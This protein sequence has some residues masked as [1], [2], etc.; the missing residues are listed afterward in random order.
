MENIVILFEKLLLDGTS[1]TGELIEELAYNIFLK[2]KQNNS[3]STAVLFEFFDI[4]QKNSLLD[5]ENSTKLIKA[6]VR[7]SVKDEENILYQYI[8]ELELLNSKIK[9][10]KN[11]VKNELSSK[12][13]EIKQKIDDKNFKV[14]ISN[15]LN[16]ALLFELET[17]D[18]LKETAESAFITTLEKAED[19]EITSSVIARQLVFNTIGESDFKKEK[20][21]K[22]SKT[23]LE[24]AFDLANESKIFAKELCIGAIKGVRDGIS[25]GIE[26]FKKSFA[27]CIVEEDINAKEKELIDI[28]DDFIAILR[29]E[30]KKYNDPAKSIIQNLLENELDTLFAKL[31]RLANESKEQLLLS[32]N[33]L[34]KNPKIDDFNKLAQS[35][36]NSFKQELSKLEKV[37]D[38]RYKELNKNEAKML[39]ISLWQKAK[40]LLRK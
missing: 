31:K 39:G 23:V 33:E 5:D 25:L 21:L 27:Y 36:I 11:I 28:E 40:K 35:K 34:K 12:F 15:S 9:R 13:F 30:L 24:C 17:L 19:V 2:Q 8:R 20:I 26:K 22:A 18:I 3:L 10:Q 29:A 37:N 16:E 38:D 7:V 4:L 32:L 14:Q 1:K 6:F